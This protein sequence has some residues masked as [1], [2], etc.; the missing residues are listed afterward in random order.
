[1]SEPLAPVVDAQSVSEVL[2]PHSS[3][4][5]LKRIDE[6]FRNNAPLDAAGAAHIIL[7]GVL[8][9][10]GEYWSAK[11]PTKSMSRSERSQKV[12]TTTRASKQRLSPL[13]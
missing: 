8:T 11:T 4:K 7:D 2:N 5:S 3:R 13:G 12:R 10:N 9:G 1:M 6:G